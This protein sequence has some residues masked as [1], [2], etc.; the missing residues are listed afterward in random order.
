[1]KIL[2]VNFSFTQGGIDNM[3]CDIMRCQ[4]QQGHDV[5][6]LIINQKIV[7]EVFANIPKQVHIYI[8]GRSEGSR[9]PWHILRT[10]WIVNVVIRPHIIHA[11]HNKVAIMLPFRFC[12]M[13]LTIHA[14]NLRPAIY[15]KYDYVVGI[16]KAVEDNAYTQTKHRFKSDVIY[17]GIDFDLIKKRNEKLAPIFRIIMVSR[18]DHEMKGHDILL[19]AAIILKKKFSKY[20]FHIDMVGD[21]KSFSFLSNM[22]QTNGLSNEVCLMGSKCR[23]WVYEHLCEYDL[24]VQPSRHEGFG[25]TLVEAI[26]AGI[27]VLSSNVDGAVEILE[28]G[29]YGYLFNSEDAEDLARQLSLIMDMNDS[30]ISQKVSDAEQNFK[31]NYSVQRMTAQYFQLYDKVLKNYKRSYI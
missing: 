14:M 6:L 10:C 24:L 25:L 2:H 9:N 22:I 30:V 5:S 26:A 15:Y 27:P 31:K 17:N 13:I 29:K 23:T 8:Q 20:K 3:M 16:T 12:P 1:M 11:H 7:E 19:N 4:I 28:N 18:L 21:G